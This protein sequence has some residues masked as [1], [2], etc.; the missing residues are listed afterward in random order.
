[1][2][3][4]QNAKK[5]KLATDG[6]LNTAERKM[7]THQPFGGRFPVGDAEWPRSGCGSDMPKPGAVYGL[8]DVAKPIPMGQSD[9]PLRFDDAHQIFFRTKPRSSEDRADK[10]TEERVPAGRRT[11]GAGEV[12]G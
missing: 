2:R 9:W 3:A 7:P 10:K 5:S 1:L 4:I 12:S 6:N 11:G 8:V